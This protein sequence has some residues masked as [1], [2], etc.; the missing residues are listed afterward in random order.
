MATDAAIRIGAVIVPP[1][2]IDM[3]SIMLSTQLVYR[4]V[5]KTEP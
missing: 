4:K 2:W 5:I 1:D 3:D